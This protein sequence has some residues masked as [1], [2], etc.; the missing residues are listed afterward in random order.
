LVLKSSPGCGGHKQELNFMKAIRLLVS[1]LIFC[2]SF[3]LARAQTYYYP[4]VTL[5]LNGKLTLTGTL[6]S[7]YCLQGTNFCTSDLLQWL[8]IDNGVTNRSGAFAFPANSSLMVNLT[9]TYT[10]PVYVLPVSDVV[11]YPPLTNLAPA[12]PSLH[13]SSTATVTNRNGQ[14]W[15]VS[16]NFMML[17][18]TGANSDTNA[19]FVSASYGQYNVDRF[20]I[21]LRYRSA[22][23]SFDIPGLASFR[24]VPSV[25]PIQPLS[26]AAS[27]F[28]SRPVFTIEHAS[29]EGINGFDPLLISGAA[30][31]S[32]TGSV[33]Y[34]PMPLGPIPLSSNP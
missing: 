25:S 5:T 16:G 32:G 33:Q 8:A 31:I 1:L 18:A 2:S 15:D 23:H 17:P 22:G 7:N 11:V 29:G 34:S 19:A 6:F 4:Q 3:T 24:Y 9:V 26:S 30:S 27:Q 20:E 21:L 12:L 13:I 14:S 28:F 10:T